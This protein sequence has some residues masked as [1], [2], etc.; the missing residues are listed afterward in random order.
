MELFSIG[1]P[2]KTKINQTLFK[3]V[4]TLKNVI[5]AQ[6]FVSLNYLQCYYI[7]KTRVYKYFSFCFIS[8]PFSDG[9]RY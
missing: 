4:V 3:V 2:F 6:N 1:M 9:V 8:K 7:P 5:I